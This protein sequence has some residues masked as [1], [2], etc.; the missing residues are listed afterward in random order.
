M[1]KVAIFVWRSFSC[2]PLVSTIDFKASAEVVYILPTILNKATAPNNIPGPCK[3]SPIPLNIPEA[4]L[5]PA[6]LVSASS[7]KPSR[8]EFNPPTRFLS[9]GLNISVPASAATF[10]KLAKVLFTIADKV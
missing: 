3:K 10:C 6:L 4:I 7:L 2:S 9:I 1:L 8:A 5:A